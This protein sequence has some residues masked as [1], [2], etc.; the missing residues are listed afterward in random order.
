MIA[1][2]GSGDVRDINSKTN[3]IA[4]ILCNK[5]N[6]QDTFLLVR[7]IPYKMLKVYKSLLV[8]WFM[9]SKRLGK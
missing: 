7:S 6:N 8:P 3:E 1:S 2:L 4:N 9:K 5:K